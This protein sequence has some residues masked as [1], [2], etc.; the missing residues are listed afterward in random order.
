MFA[1]DVAGRRVGLPDLF[2]GFGAHDRLGLV[3][4]EPCGA[5]GASALISA[6]VTAF[7]DIQRS[8]GRRLLHLSRLL[9][10][11]RRAPAGR[12]RP[13]GRVAAPQGGGRRG[14]SGGDPRG[15]R[16]PRDHPPAGGGRP[17]GGA[18]ARGRGTGQRTGNGSLTCLAYSPSGRVADADV[19]IAS[20]P[21]TE[22]YVEA[23]LDPEA[24]LARLRGRGGQR[25]ARG[26]DRAAGAARS[27]RGRAQEDRA[28]RR[29]L[30]EDGVP[31]ETYRRIDLDEALP[32][33][34]G[35]VDRRRLTPPELIYH[36]VPGAGRPLVDLEVDVGTCEREPGDPALPPDQ[37]V[38]VLLRVA[39]ARRAA[40]QH[41][42]P[43]LPPASLRRSGRGVLAAPERRDAVGRRRRRAA[44]RDQRPGRVRLHQPDRRARPEQVRGRAVQVRLQHASPTAGSSTTRCCCAS[45][46]TASG[47]RSPTATWSSGRAASRTAP[48]TT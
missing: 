10:L 12:P 5:V 30:A 23:I 46:R 20:N 44:D 31:V 35:G 14:R 24:R 1:I 16:R 27:S 38:A 45:R 19:R 41:L 9:P 39:T 32:S 25:G 43:P 4:S 17:A 15:D 36:D 18:G 40:L 6:T 37:E 42:Q 47:C 26:R 29:E 7:Y 8:R 34:A 28:A 2:E 21:V 22:G 13:T 11:P 33:L 48:T 3:M